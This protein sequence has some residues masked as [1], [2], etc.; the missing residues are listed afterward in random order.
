MSSTCVVV[1]IFKPPKVNV[2]PQVTA[3]AENGGFKWQP[4]APGFWSDEVQ[5]EQL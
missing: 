2:M 1:S 5:L 4:V 3:Y